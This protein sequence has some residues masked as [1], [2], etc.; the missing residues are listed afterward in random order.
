[1][2]VHARSTKIIGFIVYVWLSIK[3]EYGGV[4]VTKG[5]VGRW[6]GFD[7]SGRRMD[8][9]FMGP[10]GGAL[11]QFINGN[12]RLQTNISVWVY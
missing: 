3:M 2:I 11:G 8:E 4:G 5:E 7:V 12:V 10:Y 1:M 9:H 6:E